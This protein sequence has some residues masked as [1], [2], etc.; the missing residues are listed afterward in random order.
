[1]DI[2]RFLYISTGMIVRIPE[3]TKIMEA[4]IRS[5]KKPDKILLSGIASMHK[6]LCTVLTL[7]I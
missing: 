1:M 7:P 3:N 4:E 2:R 5:N 6:V